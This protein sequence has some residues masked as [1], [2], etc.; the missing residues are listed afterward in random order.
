MLMLKSGFASG[1]N[2][3]SFS[4]DDFSKININ[5]LEERLGCHETAKTFA[6]LPVDLS[7]R[8]AQRISLN[9]KS[10]LIILNITNK[11]PIESAFKFEQCN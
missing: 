11:L 3:P 6:H 2:H 5:K 4:R 1:F 10:F 8:A 9:L 7:L